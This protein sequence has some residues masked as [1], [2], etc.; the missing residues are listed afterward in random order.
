V[1][2]ARPA[3]RKEF[4]AGRTAARKLLGR[5]GIRDFPLRSGKAREPIW[6]EGIVGSLS[7]A[8]G[9]CVAAVA[10]RGELQSLG[11]DVEG[12]TDV[13]R[14]MWPHLFLEEELERLEGLPARDQP[15]Y[16]A[17]CFSAKECFYKCQFPITRAW[18]H[19]KDA[20]VTWH[21]REGTFDVTLHAKEAAPLRKG[22]RFPGRF[23]FHEDRVYTGM[24][25]R[26]GAFSQ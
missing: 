12:R 1:A 5:L 11:I 15:D 20:R 21:A 19:F 16:A 10:R 18:L 6:P 4:L 24:A 3:R 17:L 22:M 8:R 23:L 14:A 13:K 26:T 2:A 25:Y 9:C 7:H